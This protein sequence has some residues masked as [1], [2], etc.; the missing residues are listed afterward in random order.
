MPRASRR[1]RSERV[2]HLVAGVP[3]ADEAGFRMETFRACEGEERIAAERVDLDLCTRHIAAETSTRLQM[4]R[5][6]ERVL[7]SLTHVVLVDRSDGNP[8]TFPDHRS[9]EIVPPGVAKI[10]I[11]PVAHPD[12]S[13]DRYVYKER[14]GDDAV[15]D[16]HLEPDCRRNAVERPKDHD[17]EGGD[18]VRGPDHTRERT[19]CEHENREPGEEREHWPEQLVEGATAV[20]A[21]ESTLESVYLVGV[22][23]PD[24]EKSELFFERKGIDFRGA[25]CGH[26]LHVH[27]EHS[28]CERPPPTSATSMPH[29]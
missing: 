1:Y 3:R 26:G 21:Y 27:G 15:R 20:V 25:T 16:E 14:Q 9:E 10:E 24:A 18:C 22:H 12:D 2:E 8:S 6:H 13:E 11:A 23:G 19:V 7:L 28:V 17:R 29:I 5:N 4:F